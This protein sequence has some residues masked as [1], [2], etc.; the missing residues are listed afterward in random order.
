MGFR[1]I[2]V[3]INSK[4]SINLWEFDPQDTWQE[5]QQNPNTKLSMKKKSLIFIKTDVKELFDYMEL[6]ILENK[7]VR[8]IFNIYGNI[9][10]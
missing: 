7:V 3:F 8:K 2:N 10:N 5:L 9:E 6:I 1:I 4:I